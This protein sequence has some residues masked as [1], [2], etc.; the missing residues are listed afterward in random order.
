MTKN[1]FH[2]V[3]GVCLACVLA[4]LAQADPPPAGNNTYSIT[5]TAP[6]GDKTFSVHINTTTATKVTVYVNGVKV[7][8]TPSGDLDP[9]MQNFDI[10]LIDAPPAGATVLI[11]G[12]TSAT[13]GPYG[14]TASW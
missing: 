1:L 9:A 13:S 8:S 10:T 14:G 2:V 6:G 3:L 11:V 12:T 7:E 5:T 4:T